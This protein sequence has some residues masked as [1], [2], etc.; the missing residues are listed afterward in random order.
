MAQINEQMVVMGRLEKTLWRKVLG[1]MGKLVERISYMF[2]VLFVAVFVG[3]SGRSK[4]ASLGYL[5]MVLV[6]PMLGLE[7][8][9]H[10]SH[11]LIVVHRD[12]LDTLG[13]TL[14]YFVVTWGLGAYN[15]LSTEDVDFE[16]RMKRDGYDP[17]IASEVR[18]Y[19][20]YMD[21]HW[22][23]KDWE[24]RRFN[25]KV[26]KAAVVVLFPIL[27]AWSFLVGVSVF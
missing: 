23:E 7:S 25:R 14:I 3:F 27:L 22:T 13:T 20:K 16:K 21:E 11:R 10:E 4:L 19:Q 15:I 17:R 1:W 18:E 12:I 9:K 26:R 5:F 24:N 8:A 6:L 2:L